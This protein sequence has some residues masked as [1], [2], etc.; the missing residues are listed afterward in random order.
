MLSWL[1]NIRIIEK[2]AELFH[3]KI[4][5][6]PSSLHIPVMKDAQVIVSPE[7]IQFVEH[8]LIQS[9]NQSDQQVTHLLAHY[10]SL[11]TSL[12]EHQPIQSKWNYIID[13]SELNHVL[14]RCQHS[15]D[16]A[17]R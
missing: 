7:S 11:K 12:F 2:N 10:S 3:I 17:H 4:Q 1:E 5:L 13:P 9:M 6:G 15:R 16:W 8:L 14:M